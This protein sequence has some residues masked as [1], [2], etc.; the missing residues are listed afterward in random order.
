MPNADVPGGLAIFIPAWQ[1]A[2]VIGPMLRT[3]LRKWGANNY[4]LFVGTYPNDRKT[5]EVVEAIARAEAKITSVITPSM[6]RPPRPTVS[7]PYGMQWCRKKRGVENVL[8]QSYSTMLKMLCIMMP[9][10]CW[11]G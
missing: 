1:E 8:K 10:V 4:R 9:C 2:D 3:S 11:T 6:V 7:M 5:T